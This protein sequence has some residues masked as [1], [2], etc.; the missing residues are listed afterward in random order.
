MKDQHGELGKQNRSSRS[1]TFPMIQNIYEQGT[2]EIV[3]YGFPKLSFDSH[4]VTLLNTANMSKEH[5]LADF[6]KYILD[7][8]KMTPIQG[9]YIPISQ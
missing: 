4:Y 8:N 6:Y 7:P 1:Y 3:G 9:K 2:V 5:Q